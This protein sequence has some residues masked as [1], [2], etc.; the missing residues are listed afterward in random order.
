MHLLSPFP[1]SFPDVELL[2]S[3]YRCMPSSFDDEL[4]SVLALKALRV[5]T[6]VG[7]LRLMKALF[8]CH[9]NGRKLQKI[10]ASL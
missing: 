3:R 1:L 2:C 5:A 8:G 4:I 6:T 9:I 7:K 10:L